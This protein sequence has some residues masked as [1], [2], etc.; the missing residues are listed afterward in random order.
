M[1]H[2]TREYPVKKFGNDRMNPIQ[3]FVNPLSPNSDLCQISHCS[4]KGFIS[5]G[6]HEN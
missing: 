2:C 5:Q 3:C 6:G 1:L 4:V